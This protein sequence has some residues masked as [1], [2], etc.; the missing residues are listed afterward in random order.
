MAR[1]IIAKATPIEAGSITFRKTFRRGGRLVDGDDMTDTP[2]PFGRAVGEVYRELKDAIEKRDGLDG[3]VK[4][5]VSKELGDLAE[6]H[7][8]KKAW[9]LG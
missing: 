8:N 6:K 1:L 3:S 2:K 4:E 7:E 9:P 5:T